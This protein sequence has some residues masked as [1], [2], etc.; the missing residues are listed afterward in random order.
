MKLTLSRQSRRSNNS[1]R[2]IQKPLSVTNGDQP[3]TIYV[4]FLTILTIFEN[5]IFFNEGIRAMLEEEQVR[6]RK[7]QD[8][9]AKDQ[10]SS[11]KLYFITSGITGRNPSSEIGKSLLPFENCKVQQKLKG[12]RGSFS[13]FVPLPKLFFFLLRPCF[14]IW[15]SLIRNLLPIS[16]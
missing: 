5:F 8:E 12:D 11:N 7:L 16:I 4:W 3:K 6:Q 13:F 10:V 14:I 9:Y 1:V 2:N 15:I